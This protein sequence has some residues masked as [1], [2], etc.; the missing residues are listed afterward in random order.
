MVYKQILFLLHHRWESSV[1]LDIQNDQ[2]I[3]ETMKIIVTEQSVGLQ[4]IYLY[5]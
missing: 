2:S 1:I 3:I 4:V 5:F